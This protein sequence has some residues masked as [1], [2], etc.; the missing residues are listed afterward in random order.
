MRTAEQVDMILVRPNPFHL[1]RKPFRDLGSRLLDD[2][3]HRLIQQAPSGISPE[4]LCG[5]GFATH[6][7]RPFSLLRPSGP[8]Y[9]R[10]DQKRLPPQHSYGESQVEALDEAALDRFAWPKKSSWIPCR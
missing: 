5:N 9:S 10:R 4:T 7:A 8:P 2:C 3:R 1:D 6:S